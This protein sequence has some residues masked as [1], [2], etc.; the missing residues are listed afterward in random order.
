VKCADF[1][2]R[3]FRDYYQDSPVTG[4]VPAI[5]K[6]E[7]GFVS[8]E[9]RMLRHKS[10]KG[11][12][13]LTSFLRTS[14]PRDVY[15]SCAYY[16]E[17]EAEMEKKGWLGCDLVFDIDADHIPTPCDRVH[18]EW[19]CASCG[20]VGKGAVPEKCPACNS[21]KFSGNTWPC[22]VC[23]TSAK[24]ETVKLLDMLTNDFGFSERE[25]HVFFSGHRGYHIHVENSS[26][27]TLDAIARKE[28]VDYVSGYGLESHFTSLSEKDRRTIQIRQ[29]L[30]SGGSGWPRRTVSSM[31]DFVL[32][33]DEQSLMNIGVGKKEARMLLP[34]RDSI[35]K[36]WF[37][38]GT[39]GG[40]KGIGFETWRKIAEHCI[41]TK[42]AKID[43]VVTTDIHRLIRL[44]ET[45]HGKTGLRKVEFRSST[46]HSFDPF[47]SAIAFKAGLVTVLVFDAP[48]FRIGDETFGPYRNR[49]IELP[50][51]A[52]ILLVCKGKAEVVE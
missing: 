43:T 24:E 30:R 29:F 17:P 2:W 5:E 52:A 8:C 11:R 1:V 42:S 21:E 28:I 32:H 50:T 47:K 27:N 49:K 44:A 35:L 6:R 31:E 19:T 38:A 18:D 7:F 40:V 13:D 15:V 3:A 51:A 9:G 39:F 36:E 34:N 22:E 12:E 10:F 37:E 14:V 20:F 25:M 41:R 23:L 4:S 45:L 46:I 33:A 16:E 26:T 48:E